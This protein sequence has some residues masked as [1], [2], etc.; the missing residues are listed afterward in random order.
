MKI[1]HL[2]AAASI[3]ALTATSANALEHATSSNT[4]FQDTLALELTGISTGAAAV[5]G[6]LEYDVQLTSLGSFPDG[7]DLVVTVSLP[8]G[9]EFDV[10]NVAGT[11]I[12]TDTNT[13]PDSD[14]TSGDNG[15]VFTTSPGEVVYNITVPTGATVEAV[16]LSI[17]VVYKQCV[18][19]SAAVS[20][21]ITTGG[22]HIEN[23]TNGAQSTAILPGCASAIDGVVT[24]DGVDKE[25]LQVPGP[26]TTIGDTLLGNYVYTINSTVAI[27]AFGTPLTVS[28]I[29]SIG[30]TTTVEDKTG[31]QGFTV[32]ATTAGFGLGQSVSLNDPVGILG[33]LSSDINVNDGPSGAIVT[34]DVNISTQVNFSTLGLSDEAPIGAAPIDSLDRQGQTFGWFDWVGSNASNTITVLRVTGLPKGDDIRYTVQFRNTNDGTDATYNG[35]A[36][37]ADLADSEFALYS[38]TGF[39]TSN[40]DYTRGDVLV[41]FETAVTT[42]DVDRLMIRNNVISAYNDGSNSNDNN[43]VTPDADADNAP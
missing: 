37:A 8:A 36:T 5:H 7:N 2:L 32:G 24:A 21:T 27:D 28:D 9:V 15:T 17:P 29:A 35:T 41:T 12:S 26:Y 39:G 25:I 23:D 40:A 11:D 1:K 18:G 43:G 16:V 33:D 22:V 38:H 19:S 3:V 31:L 6:S 13:D 14:T 42:V 34:Q 30:S 4:D 20:T 10:A